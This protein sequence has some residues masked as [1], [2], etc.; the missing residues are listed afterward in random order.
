MTTGAGALLRNHLEET[1]LPSEHRFITDEYRINHI[2]RN[3]LPA[4]PI[5]EQIAVS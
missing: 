2:L 5:S 3:F 4:G 1:A